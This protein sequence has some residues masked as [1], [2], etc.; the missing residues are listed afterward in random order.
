MA[1]VLTSCHMLV[2]VVFV[3]HT[4]FFVFPIGWE[5]LLL[6]FMTFLHVS[7]IMKMQHGT[8]VNVLLQAS[9]FLLFETLTFLLVKW[10]QGFECDILTLQECDFLTLQDPPPPPHLFQANKQKRTVEF[11]NVSNLKQTKSAHVLKRPLWSFT[12]LH[13]KRAMKQ[14]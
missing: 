5:P 7:L 11:R 4:W 13:M 10:T 3:W 8:G 12:I 14:G 1:Q 2:L 6:F 9:G